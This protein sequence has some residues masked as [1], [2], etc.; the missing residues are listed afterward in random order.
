MPGPRDTS[1]LDLRGGLPFPEP[2]AALSMRSTT[3]YRAVDEDG[4]PI[5]IVT[6]GVTTVALESG[7]SGLSEEVVAA[8]E[9]LASATRDYA[10]SLRAS[11]QPRR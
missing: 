3:V 1:T 2:V 11:W 7:L 5:L 4:Q 9:G 10:T 6:D 8:A